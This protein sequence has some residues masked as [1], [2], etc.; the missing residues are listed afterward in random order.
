MS[1]TTSVYDKCIIKPSIQQQQN[2]RRSSEHKITLYTD[3]H[4]DTQMDTQ[5]HR[6]THRYTDEQTDTQ[7]DTQMD[8]D[9]QMDIQTV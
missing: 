7:M 4:T 9:I 5:I 3:G 8:T 6:W 1:C 2:F